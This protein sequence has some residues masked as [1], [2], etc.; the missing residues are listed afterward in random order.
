MKTPEQCKHGGV[1]AWCPVCKEMNAI[2][3]K[4]EKTSKM[5]NFH[6]GNADDKVY[7]VPF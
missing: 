7:V 2:N 6:A 5:K 3:K 4:N 1:K